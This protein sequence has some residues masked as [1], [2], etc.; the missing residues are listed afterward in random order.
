MTAFPKMANGSYPKLRK[1]ANGESCIA[2]GRQTET[3]VLAHRN[4][5]KAGGKKLMPDYLA[6]DLCCVC[7]AEY[8]QGH[9][10]TREEKRAFFNEHYPKQVQRWFAKGLV[11]VA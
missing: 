4:E 6:L 5:G 9:T 3:T 8:D 2:C 7:H 1:A 10:W 11:K